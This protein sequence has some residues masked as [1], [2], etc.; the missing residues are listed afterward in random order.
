MGVPDLEESMKRLE[1]L[2]PVELLGMSNLLCIDPLSCSS[3]RLNMLSSNVPQAYLPNGAEPPLAFT[4]Y[5]NKFGKYLFND[6]TVKEDSYIKAVIPRN[7]VRHGSRVPSYTIILASIDGTLD[8]MEIDS[9]YQ[10]AKT[11][12][13]ESVMVNGHLLHTDEFI[14]AGT[15]FTKS[16]AFDEYDNYCQGV[17]VNVAMMTDM[18]VPEDSFR[19]SESCAKK[20]ES[21]AINTIS[22]SVAKD[23][24]PLTLYGDGKCMPDVG[25][26]VKDHGILMGIRKINQESALTDMDKESLS[27]PD[28][29]HDELFVAPEGS[30]VIGIEVI[31]NNR[32]MSELGGEGSIYSQ[33]CDY[34]DAMNTYYKNVVTEYHKLMFEN[35]NYKTTDEFNSLVMYC[36]S[37]QPSERNRMQKL[38]RVK[39]KHDIEFCTIKLT[40]KYTRPVGAAFKFTGRDGAKGVIPNITPDEDMPIDEDGIRSDFVISSDSPL[41]RLNNVQLEEMDVNRCGELIRLR[42]LNGTIPMDKAL[43]SILDFLEIVCPPYRRIIQRTVIERGTQEEYLEMCLEKG[44]RKQIIPGSKHM[45]EDMIRRLDARFNIRK[46]FVTFATRDKNGVRKV[47]RSQEPVMIGSKYMYVLCKIPLLE[48]SA[49][50]YAHISHHG[51]PIKPRSDRTKGQSLCGKT[52]IKMGED[53]TALATHSIGTK[54]VARLHGLSNSPIAVKKL[55]Q[56]QLSADK[57]SDIGGV[58]MTDKEV[59]TTSRMVQICD[60]V[61]VPCGFH[62]VTIGDTK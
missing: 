24:V 47:E 37:L 12:G 14:S 20:F 36:L 4:G 46:T 42:I 18:R 43:S 49:M 60:E 11:F 48:M 29:I 56:L 2:V 33:L 5:E 3:Q 59:V 1:T 31:G 55:Q 17:N 21:T 15:Q 9:F 57:P 26:V 8:V 50:E 54:P 58:P 27:T 19:I 13:F 16:P 44:I 30:T 61:S 51:V 6:T 7:V 52:P 25:E 45:N 34:N 38:K 10:G 28:Y 53:E 39:R 41:N 22:I 32:V 23:E 40:Y 35:P 62:P